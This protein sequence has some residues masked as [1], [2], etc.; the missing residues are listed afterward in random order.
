MTCRPHREVILDLARDVAV[1]SAAV[2]AAEAHIGICAACAAE[3]ERQRNLTAALSGLSAEARHW[4]AA[5]DLEHR[6][7]ETFAASHSRVLTQ[8]VA[9]SRG[10]WWYAPLAAAALVALVVWMVQRRPDVRVPV[11]AR[12]PSPSV[13]HPVPRVLPAVEKAATA[14][15][16]RVDGRG[17]EGRAHAGS[18]ARRASRVANEVRPVEFMQIPGAAGLPP[19]ES[20][21][22]VRIQ[23]PIP[24]LPTYGLQIVPGGARSGIEADVLVGQDG[25]ARA[26]R[27]L[28]TQPESRSGQ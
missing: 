19:L 15:A 11:V 21:S 26:I 14:N 16:G 8:P 20:G 4:R 12:M 6:L 5:G 23:V 17:A 7:L 24:E 27:V 2:G 1:P 22:I 18:R 3:L 25:R 13:E 28:G 10:R 9:G